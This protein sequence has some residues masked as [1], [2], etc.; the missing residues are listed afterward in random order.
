MAELQ[1]HRRR[2]VFEKFA[3]AINIEIAK[4]DHRKIGCFHPIIGQVVHCQFAEA[5]DV[6]RIL[7]P[8]RLRSRSVAVGG[9]RTGID[10]R[11]THLLGHHKQIFERI[12][13]GIDHD[14]LIVNRRVADCRFVED[15]VEPKIEK[16][17]KI[18]TIVDIARDNLSPEPIEIF[19]VAKAFEVAVAESLAC[20][21]KIEYDHFGIGKVLLKP[22]CQIGAD[23]TSPSRNKYRFS[24]EVHYQ[25]A[26]KSLYVA[27]SII[28]CFSRASATNLSSTSDAVS[29]IQS[30][31]HCSHTVAGTSRITTT[32]K[33][34]STVKVVAP[35]RQFPPHIG[36]LIA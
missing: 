26:F 6:G 19:V 33:P 13:I 20:T 18:L 9:A 24:I 30:A 23:E 16:T 11:R 1:H 31:P 3:W 36:H 15:E 25:L 22:E 10:H 5:I 7:T 4:S 2:F 14:F 29:S 21:E 17:F 12:E 27:T 34:R 32:P 28:A 35:S 8:H